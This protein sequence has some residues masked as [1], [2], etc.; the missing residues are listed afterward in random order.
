MNDEV[1]PKSR[2]VDAPE[3]QVSCERTLGA[4]DGPALLVVRLAPPPP[5]RF[6]RP[7]RIRVDE[8]CCRCLAIAVRQRGGLYDETDCRA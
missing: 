8:Q 5:L 2:G 6:V 4:S 7:M 3:G 1:E